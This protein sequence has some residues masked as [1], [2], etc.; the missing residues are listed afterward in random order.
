[1]YEFNGDLD[2]TSLLNE[3]LEI[4]RW[5]IRYRW[6]STLEFIGDSK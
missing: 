5:I 1:M 3:Y 2:K 6:K 4:V